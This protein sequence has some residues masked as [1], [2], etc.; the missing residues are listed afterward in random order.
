[1]RRGVAFITLSAGLALS[2]CGRDQGHQQ[3]QAVTEKVASAEVVIPVDQQ[4]GA[5]STERIQPSAVPE[6]LRVRGRITLPDNGNWRVGAVAAGRVETVLVSLGDYVRQ[7][8][9]V[10]R[11]HSHDVHE[12]KAEY[13]TALSE[14][15]RLQ[16]AEAIAQ[17]NYERTQRLYGLKAASLEQTELA[18]QQWLDAQTATHHSDIAVERER[19]HLEEN[20]GIP[21]PSTEKGGERA[22]LIPIRAPGSGYIVQKSVTPGT[23]VEPSTDMFVI[24]EL[25]RLWLLAS[26]REDYLG[27]LR[28]GQKA[29]LNVSNLPGL[30]AEG[31]IANV[32]EQFDPI[33]HAMRVRIEFDNPQNR[34]RPE[35]L[36]EAVIAVGNA[37]PMLLVPGDAVQQ[38]Q[39]QDVVF[40][41][42]ASDKFAMRAVRTAAQ[43]DDKVAILE[44]LKAGEQ[45]VTRGSFVLKSEMLKSQMQGE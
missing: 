18:R 2:G 33:T 26:V 43:V 23:V 30:R 9:V 40:V 25:G 29:T 34:F 31:R 1:M 14:R 38:I 20:L 17:R 5:I 16:A 44:G 41:R 22:E 27:K 45:V 21:A 15:S 28:I 11:M 7:G 19:A 12:A 8:Q 42:T 6:L 35:M 36:A 4:T 37:K 13:L 3:A 39:G 10:A 24:G 32:G